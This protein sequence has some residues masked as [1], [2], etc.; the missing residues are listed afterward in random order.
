[1][2]NTV[3]GRVLLFRKVQGRVEEMISSGGEVCSRTD[4]IA[5]AI[6]PAAW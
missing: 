4:S 3:N 6:E 5:S 2:G 1:M